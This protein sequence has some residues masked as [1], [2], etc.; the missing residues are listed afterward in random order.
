MNYIKNDLAELKKEIIEAK[1][2]RKLARTSGDMSEAHYN[3]RK[4]KE[5]FR[6]KHVAY[7]LLRGKQYL[8]IENSVRE[9]NGI[10]KGMLNLA[11]IGYPSLHF[12]EIPEEN[13]EGLSRW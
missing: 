7:C 10:T 8:Q 3:V 5:S 13:L 4:L 2:I 6:L 11:L 1:R 12:S 9:N